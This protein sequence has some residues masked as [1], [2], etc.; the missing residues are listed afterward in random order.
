MIDLPIRKGLQKL[1][2][3]G[4]MVR[5]SVKLSEFDI[6]YEPRESIKGHVYADFVVELMSGVLTQ[7]PGVFGGY[8]Q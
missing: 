3:V 4:C 2:I 7:I 1:D 6:H 5:W 8:C